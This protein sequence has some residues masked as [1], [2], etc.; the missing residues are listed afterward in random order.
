MKIILN[1]LCLAVLIVI[2]LSCQKTK[3]KLTEFDIDYST[4]LAVPANSYTADV[5]A[6]FTSPEI[7]TDSKNKFSAQK[8]ASDR[9]NEIK[10]TRFN[11]SVNA[12]TLDALKSIKIFLKTTGRPDLEIATKTSVPA[13]VTSVSADLADVNIKEY[14]FNDKI[15]FRVQLTIGGGSKIDQQIKMDQTMHVK[16]KLIN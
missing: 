2:G 1:G 4:N 3:E 7:S 6:D 13:G 14:I 8:T 12:G 11:I 15:Q 16:A 5:P 10:L 9:I